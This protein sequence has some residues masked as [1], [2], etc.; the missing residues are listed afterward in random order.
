M[1]V[2][3]L[4]V[5]VSVSLSATDIDGSGVDETYYTLDGTTPTTGSTP[6]VGPFVVDRSSVVRFFSTDRTGN[7]EL[8][9]SATVYVNGAPTHVALTWD[10]GTI[11]QYELAFELAL[12]PTA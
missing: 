11:S 9:R 2:R 1:H 7:A 12:C 6:Y 8:P 5:G 10:D 4:R 3:S